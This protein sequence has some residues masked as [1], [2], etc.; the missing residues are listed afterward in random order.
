MPSQDGMSASPL[1][2]DISASGQHVR[3]GPIADIGR[4]SIN[5]LVGCGKYRLRNTETERPC[6]FQI[7]N[8]LVFGWGL[9]RHVTWFL[10]LENAVDIFRGLAERLVRVRPIAHQTTICR[11]IAIGVNSRQ[12]VASYELDDDLATTTRR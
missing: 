9:H 4:G 8:Q 5:Q 12:L 3:C 10:A 2:A 7:D 6:G 1:K 11:K